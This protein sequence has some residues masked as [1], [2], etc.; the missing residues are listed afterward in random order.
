MGVATWAVPWRGS[1]QLAAV[2]L[3][4]EKLIGPALFD[5]VRL[6]VPA[7]KKPHQSD[8]IWST[9]DTTCGGWPRIRL[10]HI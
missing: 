6:K 7:E 1:A 8:R 5:S 9:R 10:D 2:Q 4:M 3:V